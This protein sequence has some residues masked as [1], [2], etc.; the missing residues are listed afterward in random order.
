MKVIDKAILLSFLTVHATHASTVLVDF[1]R[2]GTLG[3]PDLRT[4]SSSPTYN[5]LALGNGGASTF[6]LT[7]T[8]LTTIPIADNGGTAAASS[9]ALVDTVGASSGI[10]ISFQAARQNGTFGSNGQVGT[11]GTGGNYTGNLPSDVSSLA[12]NATTDGLFL[13]NSS[14]LRVTL[15]GLNNS[16]SYNLIA[17]SGRNTADTNGGAI[18]SLLTGSAA[19]SHFQNSSGTYTSNTGQLVNSTGTDSAIA[20]EWLGVT[21]SGG[22]IAFVITSKVNTSGAV[23]LNALSFVSVPEPSG[24][25]LFSI[26]M[27]TLGFFTRRRVS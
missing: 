9:A 22:S 25:A 23:G 21:P 14:V 26:G 10:T 8:S 12:S 11:S 4:T 3:S 17:L 13:N 24:I 2:N 27:M 5:N 18:W 19:T 20:A 15:T 1:G 6:S 7:S 16:L